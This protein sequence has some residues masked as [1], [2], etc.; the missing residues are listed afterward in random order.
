MCLL[1]L[2]LQSETS[3]ATELSGEKVTLVSKDG[4]SFEIPKEIAHQ[5]KLI[6]NI[7]TTPDNDGSDGASNSASASEGT[8]KN[9]EVPV[10][11]V[12]DDVLAKVIKFMKHH[13][14]NPM[15][16]IERPIPSDN[17]ED[18]AQDPFDRVRSAQLIVQCPLLWLW[19][20]VS[21]PATSRPPL[22]FR[23]ALQ[24]FVNVA[25][26]TLFNLISAA[27]FLDIPPLLDLTCAKVGHSPD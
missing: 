18:I 17:M 8:S 21:W 12:E 22:N 11:V 13:H 20:H 25:Q 27:N 26:E 19:R 3:T 16:E 6:R 5:S 1:W 2:Y 15:A 23:Y 14:N 7:I 4:N 9:I 10:R 24:E